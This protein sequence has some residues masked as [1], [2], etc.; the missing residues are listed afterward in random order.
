ME[1][2]D[3]E[4]EK[5]KELNINY[6][7]KIQKEIKQMKKYIKVLSNYIDTEKYEYALKVLENIIK[8]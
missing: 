3:Q 7:E 1:L 2:D 5:T 6:K 8:E 4:L